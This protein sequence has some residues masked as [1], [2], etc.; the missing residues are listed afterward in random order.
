MFGLLNIDKPAG[1]TSRAVV[2]TV[3]NLLPRKTKIGH[4]GTLDPMATGVL[5]LCIGHATRLVPQVQELRKSYRAGFRLGCRSDTDDVTGDVELVADARAV[6]CEEVERELAQFRGRI[7]QAPPRYS[8]L[9]VQ[10]KRAYDLA[11]SGVEVEL[12]PREVEVTRIELL[13]MNGA[14]LV[15]DI[16]CSSG[17]YVRSI[18]RDLGDALGVGGLMTSLVRTAIGPF[19]IEEAIKFDEL[20]RASLDARMLDPLLAVADR[21][22]CTLTDERVAAVRRGMPTPAV[23]IEPGFA[24]EIAAVDERGRLIA[25]GRLNPAGRFQPETVFGLE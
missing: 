15:V 11:R 24:G 1:L 17:T 16:D 2:N 7:L 8:A 4:A 13:E 5:M 3:H 25:L 6:S 21:P 19:R 22:R 9:W 14:D 10:G 23:D 18:G 20:S 12:T